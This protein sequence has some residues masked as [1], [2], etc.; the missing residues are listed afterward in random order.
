MTEPDVTL[1][2]YALAILC[3]GFAWNLW[4]HKTSAHT[5]K[6][7]WVLFFCSIVMASLTGGTVHGFFVDSKT[8]GYQILWPATLLAIGLTAALAWTI[9]GVL[10]TGSKWIKAWIFFA[11]ADFIFYAVIVLFFTQKFAVVILNYIPSM[12]GLLI[13]AGYRTLLLEEEGSRLISIGI[14]ISFF[15]A[16]IQQAQ[17]GLHPQYFNHNSLYHLIQALGLWMLYNGSQKL[18]S[19]ST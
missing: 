9:A 2:D 11:G 6:L 12:I 16:F 10:L 14:G 17:I 15:A 5:L 8:I 7:C 19:S 4:R 3:T 1:T 18:I 13:A